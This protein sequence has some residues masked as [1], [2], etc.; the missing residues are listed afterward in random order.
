MEGPV[1]EPGYGQPTKGLWSSCGDMGIGKDCR[2]GE[3]P[4]IRITGVV[5]LRAAGSDQWPIVG[6]SSTADLLPVDDPVYCVL[7]RAE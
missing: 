5:S 4:V 3:S 2:L 6:L 1:Y 7:L